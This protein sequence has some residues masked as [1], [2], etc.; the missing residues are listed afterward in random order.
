MAHLYDNFDSAYN[1]LASGFADAKKYKKW[2][3]EN[4]QAAYSEASNPVDKTSFGKATYAIECLCTAFNHLAALHA[5]AYDRSPLYEAI[6]W[7]GQAGDGITMQDV[8]DAWSP[9]GTDPFEAYKLT[10]DKILETMYDSDK[11]RWFHFI[12]YIDAMRAGIWNTEIYETHL[13]D[14]YRH[15]SL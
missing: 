14:M 4:A 2:A 7:A 15:F 8:L 11:L 9:D 12:N 3:L 1:G 6:Y 10:M 5:T 13:A